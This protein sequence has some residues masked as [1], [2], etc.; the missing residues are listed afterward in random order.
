[1]KPPMSERSGISISTTDRSGYSLPV[2]SG[3]APSRWPSSMTI[4]DCAA[5]SSGICRRPPRIW[6]TGLLRRSRNEVCRVRS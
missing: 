6:C 1:M 2:A 3:N 4:R 5:M